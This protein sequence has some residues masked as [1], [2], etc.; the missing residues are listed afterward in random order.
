M[1]V[2]DRAALSVIPM[3]RSAVK[4]FL[5]HRNAMLLIDEA[6]IYPGQEIVGSRIEA[7]KFLSPSSLHFDGHFP[8]FSIFPGMLTA[9]GLAQASALL[10]AY[11]KDGEFEDM[12]VV[13]SEVRKMKLLCPV[14]PGDTLHFR[15]EIIMA[16][17]PKCACKVRAYILTLRKGGKFREI[18][19]A[20]GEIEGMAI[21][22]EKL[23]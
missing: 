13:L 19:V 4:R 18:T 6:E 8:G 15:A 11:L 14:R 16:D 2:S 20:K 1:T 3:N 22:K 7:H 9:E 17:G 23:A 21:A 12:I 10:Y 5:P